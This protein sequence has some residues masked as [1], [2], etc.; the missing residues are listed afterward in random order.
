MTWIVYLTGGLLTAAVPGGSEPG[1]PQQPSILSFDKTISRVTLEAYLSRSIT[2]MDFATGRGNVE[3]NLRMLEETGARFAGR[4]LYMWGGES[5]MEGKIAKAEEIAALAHKR[6]P[7]L[8]LQG[9]V[10]EIVTTEV[11]QIPVPPWAFDAFGLP[12]E[13]RR[14]HYEDMLFPDGTFKDHWREGA[15]VPD[16]TQLETKLWFF[17]VSARYIEAGMEALHMG[18]VRLIGAHDRE[19]SHWWELL[20]KIREYA[21]AHARRH[22]VLMDAHTPSGGPLYQKDKLLFDF[23][24]FP[25]RIEEVNEEPQKGI[26]KVGYLD[27]LFL[28]SKGGVTPSGWRC[29]SLPYLV[30]LDNFERSG[31][32]GQNIGRHWIWGYDEICWFAHQ[33]E[34]YRNEWLRYAWDWIRETDPQG[35]LQMPGSRCL[36]APVE[37]KG[38]WYHANRP[39]E[40]T[41]QGFNQENTIRT[42]W[43]KHAP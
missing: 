9:A 30:E 22:L 1:G 36:A 34:D 43:E 6:M 3:D 15:S 39:S 31:K 13:K 24:S 41:P 5:Q 2:M 17:T 28:R 14:F 10:F 7:S 33:P 8:I 25:L 23:H 26:L 27:S 19:L 20:S 21:Q 12:Q 18:Q 35:F 32:E 16:M 37:E 40:A 29:D 38:H 11:N 42:L 4:T